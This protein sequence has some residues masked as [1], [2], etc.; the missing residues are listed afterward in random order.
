MA[1]VK[2]N[3]LK[4]PSGSQSAPMKISKQAQGLAKLKVPQ[5]PSAPTRRA[6][7]TS[8]SEVGPISPG[9][10]LL[11][12]APWTTGSPAIQ[13]TCQVIEAGPGLPPNMILCSI[14]GINEAS[15]VDELLLS[16]MAHGQESL[17]RYLHVCPS[18]PCTEADP[19]TLHC[20][21][22]KVLDDYIPKWGLNVVNLT[23]EQWNALS[24]A[25]RSQP[26]MDPS[27]ARL[28]GLAREWGFGLKGVKDLPPAVQD[29]EVTEAPALTA[30]PPTPTEAMLL[31]AEVESL[32]K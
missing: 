1:P 4:R 12:E 13:I 30:G 24:S 23:L 21:S 3:V 29:R 6:P 10:D 19:S 11:I 7:K 15:A 32:R 28:A 22:I 31:R 20:V 5:T 17:Q 25:P 27:M 2:K 18:H 8:L 9:M 26:N 14:K 16:Q